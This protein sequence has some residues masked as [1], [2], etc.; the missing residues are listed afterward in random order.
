M[1]H[2]RQTIRH[3]V[4]TILAGRTAAGDRVFTTREIPLRRTQLPAITIY[5]LEESAEVGAGGDHV[6]KLD[7]SLQLELLIIASLTEAVDDE[8]DAI[9]EQVE[10]AMRADPALG[11]DGTVF[12][13]ALTGTVIGVDDDQ[14]HPIGAMR[15]TY[16]VQYCTD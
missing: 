9:A 1:A 13:S 15:L 5:S 8:L 12:D 14:G 4:R 2:A 10:S 11:L 6:T 3:S 7:R 16:N